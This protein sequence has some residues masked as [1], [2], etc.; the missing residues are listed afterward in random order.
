[1]E[2]FNHVSFSFL[3]QDL[4]NFIGT[5]RIGISLINILAGISCEARFSWKLGIKYAFLGLRIIFL[6]QNACAR[7]LRIHSQTGAPLFPGFINGIFCLMTF[8]CHN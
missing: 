5:M 4:G 3:K 2:P 6:L 8:F 1:M 7:E